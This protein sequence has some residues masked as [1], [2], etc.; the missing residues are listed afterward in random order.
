MK[1]TTILKDELGLLKADTSAVLIELESLGDELK[2]TQ[3]EVEKSEKDLAD[4]KNL[5]EEETARRD[6]MHV[7]VVFL[8]SEEGALKHELNT[9]SIKTE[10]ARNKNSQEIKLHLGRIKELS[11][12]E[13]SLGSSIGELKKTY[14]N[15]VTAMN[16]NLIELNS[17]VKNTNSILV[18]TTKELRETQV[19]M[20][21]LRG[22][23]KKLTKD[24]LR[25]EDKIRA[26]EK[27]INREEHGLRLR[28]ADLQ[29]MAG[30]LIIVYS[31]LKELYAKVDPK[32]DIDKLITK[33]T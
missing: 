8:R 4:V 31:R 14:D 16:N 17:R 33:A 1:T 24:R 30:D 26:R 11:E 13:H 29:T 32:V 21:K 9:L 12:E 18:V 10:V 28:G 2:N 25:R 19:V 7:R 5:I 27:S 6:D 22:E 3:E 15:N 20:D 23:E